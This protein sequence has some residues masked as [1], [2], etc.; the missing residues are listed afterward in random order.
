MNLKYRINNR[1]QKHSLDIDCNNKSTIFIAGMGRSGTT[2]LSELINYKKNY[3]DIFE[4]FLPY[5][6][7]DASAF[8]YLQYLNP[9]YDDTVLANS[10]KTILSGKFKSEWTDVNN[11]RIITF[12]R[13]IK[14]IRANLMLK[15]LSNIRPGM[16]ILLIMRH[17][18]A[19][20]DSYKNL[21]WGIEAGGKTS[22]FDRITQQ[23][24]LL[25]DFPIINNNFKHIDTD[26]YISQLLYIWCILYHV[27]IKQL[28][29]TD[30]KI[31]YYENL[32]LHPEETLRDIFLYIGQKFDRKIVLDKIKKPSITNYRKTD[33][34]TDPTENVQKWKKSFTK[35]EK[36]KSRE[37]IKSFELDY[38]YDNDGFPA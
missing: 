31:V 2:W 13:I 1:L 15:W 37:I 7:P 32:L 11:S 6:V 27:P 28:N 9:N 33:F 24:Q 25:M 16:P 23:K 18:L 14:D 34:N 30:Y 20:I 35:N 38:L 22:D 4:P 21:G 10:A 12:K 29:N 3:R 8:N 5:K 26:D 17:P 36:N 19:V